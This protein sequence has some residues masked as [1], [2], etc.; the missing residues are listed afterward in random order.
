M[1]AS[2]QEHQLIIEELS[3]YEWVHADRQPVDGYVHDAITEV[4]VKVDRPRDGIEG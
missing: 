4:V 2:R 3:V 1:I